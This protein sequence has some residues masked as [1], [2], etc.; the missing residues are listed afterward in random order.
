MFVQPCRLATYSCPAAT[1]AREIDAAGQQVGGSPPAWLLCPHA[2][3]QPRS[4]GGGQGA[5][6]VKFHSA[7]AYAPTQHLIAHGGLG[8]GHVGRWWTLFLS[9]RFLLAGNGELEYMFQE[10]FAFFL[11]Q[12]VG[13]CS[14]RA[15]LRGPSVIRRAAGVGRGL[16]RILSLAL[17]AAAGT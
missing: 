2:G 4:V 5:I 12:G 10:G 8:L 16:H 1:W 11:A 14:G 17:R 3:L 15:L 7:G 6:V 9:K 13:I